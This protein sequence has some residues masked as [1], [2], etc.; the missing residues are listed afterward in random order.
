MKKS[1]THLPQIKQD[2]LKLIVDKICEFASPEMI[3]LYG[4][5]AR[6]DWEN[7]QHA[8]RRGRL[9]IHR[10]SDYD[11]LVVTEEKST[12]QDTAL[13]Q[14]ISKKCTTLK[15]TTRVRVIAHDIQFV[16]IRLAEGR[17]FL[18]DIRKEG[19]ML[20]DTG[21]FKLARKRKLKPFEQ[22]RIVQNYFDEWFGSAEEFY[23]Y[24]EYGLKKRQ[25]K[26]A[27]FLLHQATERCLKAVLLVFTGY[28]PHE[29][30]L[31][32]LC[33]EVA[34]FDPAFSRIFPKETDE[35]KERF[36]LLEYAY[37]GTRYDLE[38]YMTADELKY[39][40]RYVKKLHEVT[41]RICKEKIE[42]LV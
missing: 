30:W 41:E 12:A 16:N 23:G 40:S 26:T 7:G 11:I 36:E 3:I 6:G 35:Q 10:T 1:L 32:L 38:F 29:H 42:G 31:D 18:G 24:Y 17:Y 13:W 9:I 34:G 28:A 27:A 5:Y 22:Q 21:R 8:Q 39:L 15:L 33:D 2:E 19:V 20:Y 25:Y 37:I 14:K 4:S